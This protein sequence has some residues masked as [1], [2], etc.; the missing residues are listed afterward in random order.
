MIRF[1]SFVIAAVSAAF[2]ALAGSALAAVNP[3]ATVYDVASGASLITP[4][5]NGD[6]WFTSEAGKRTSIFS[7]TPDGVVTKE[8]QSRQNPRGIATGPDG[9]V[10]V[11]ASNSDSD[12]KA[13]ITRVVPGGDR[14][15]FLEGISPG[16]IPEDI[17]TG[18]DGALWFTESGRP[19]VGR[20]TTD[21]QVTEFDVPGAVDGTREITAG[22][23]GR[24]WFTLDGSHKVG[25]ITTGGDVELYGTGVQGCCTDDAITPGPDGR[26]WFSGGG[27]ADK[28]FAIAPDGDVE[29]IATLGYAAGVDGLTTGPDGNVWAIEQL[30]YVARITPEGEIVELTAGEEP[31]T[32]FSRDIVAGPD[33]N[34]WYSANSGPI[35]K[36]APVVNDT[37]QPDTTLVSTPPKRIVTNARKLDLTYEIEATPGAELGCTLDLFTRVF[38]D[39]K[40]CAPGEVTFTERKIRGKWY[41]RTLLVSAE[42]NGVIDSTPSLHTVVIKNKKKKK[43]GGHGGK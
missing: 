16:A 5:P 29:E 11:V 6:V 8:A 7:I 12:S 10:W 30:G 19:A 20:V 38:F 36:L 34:L 33:G 40:P 4:G 26:V 1:T 43:A 24:L 23:D 13:R 28:V 31:D 42:A 35:A 18:P 15:E 37:T 3:E 21:G 17:V 2:L 9:N 32:E 39:P 27:K 41:P 14:T 22:P 25:A